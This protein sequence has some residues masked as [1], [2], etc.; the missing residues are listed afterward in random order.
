MIINNN[1]NNSG[2]YLQRPTDA[3]EIYRELLEL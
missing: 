2:S 1:Q 3:H